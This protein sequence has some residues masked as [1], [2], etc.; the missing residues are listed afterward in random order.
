MKM[1]VC[2]E[3]IVILMCSDLPERLKVE[4]TK[5]IPATVTGYHYKATSRSPWYVDES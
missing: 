5:A 1:F 2:R 4:Q 3:A